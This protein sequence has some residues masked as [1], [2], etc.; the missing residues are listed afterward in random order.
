MKKK[1]FLIIALM[2]LVIP[3]SVKKVSNRIYLEKNTVY[4]AKQSV[5]VSGAKTGAEVGT[6]VGGKTTNELGD[7]KADCAGIAAIVYYGVYVVKVIQIIVPIVLIIWGSIDLI[8]SII[9]G[10]EKK[11]SAA[12]KPFIQRLVSAVI[13]FLL[14]WIVNFF[15]GSISSSA[16]DDW[17]AC[18]KAA[19]NGGNRADISPDQDDLDL[20]SP[21]AE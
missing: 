17:K 15:V 4:A 10:D 3:I 20:W 14:P 11:I 9:S 18:W 8:K 19:W 7:G 13:V 6:K 21:P 1:L 12:R 16:N 2:L 5:I